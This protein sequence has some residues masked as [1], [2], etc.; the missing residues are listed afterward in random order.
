MGKAANAAL[1]DAGLERRDID[2]SVRM[3]GHAGPNL[4]IGD[5]V[6]AAFREHQGRFLPCFELA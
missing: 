5:R 3:M 1:G 2:E 6:K 4:A